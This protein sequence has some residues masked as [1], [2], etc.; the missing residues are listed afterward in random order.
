M[1]A[2]LPKMAQRRRESERARK[3]DAPRRWAIIM[4]ENKKAIEHNLGI[5][6]EDASI[7]FRPC[8]NKSCGERRA[9]H[10]RQHE[11]RGQQYVQVASTYPDSKPVY[12]S[13]TCAGQDGVWD[14]RTGFKE[15]VEKY[16]RALNSK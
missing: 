1:S 3:R 7:K 15:P 13:Y 16:S 5:R 11:R 6:L 2:K 14:V 12:C 8:T 10:E 4:A 9:H